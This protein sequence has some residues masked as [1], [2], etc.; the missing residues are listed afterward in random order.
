MSIELPGILRWG[1]FTLLIQYAAT[2]RASQAAFH[3]SF[4]VLLGVFAQRAGWL[5]LEQ[6]A[7]L[8]Q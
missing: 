1:P 2:Q 3:L 6:F 7:G 8:L 5:F 4:A